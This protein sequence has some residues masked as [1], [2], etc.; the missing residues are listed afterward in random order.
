M[1]YQDGPLMASQMS[2]QRAAEKGRLQIDE[3][4]V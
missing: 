3:T 4:G 1:D 2:S